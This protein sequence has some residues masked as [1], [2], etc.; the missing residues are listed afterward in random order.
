M[1]CNRAG[2]F[3]A[4][5]TQIGVN[6]TGN[7]PKCTVQI[8]YSLVQEEQG[9]EFVD[10]TDE[11]LT[12]TGYHYLEKNDKSLNL[13][14]VDALKAAL[15]WNPADGVAWLQDTDLSQHAVTVVVEMSEYNGTTRPKVQYLNPLGQAGG[16]SGVA[17][18]EPAALKQINNRLGSQLRALGG[19]TP[20]KAPAP[21]GKPTAPPP[22]KKLAGSAPAA[23]ITPC[24]REQAWEAVQDAEKWAALLAE[25]KIEDEEAATEADWGRVAVLAKSPF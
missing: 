3:N 8:S 5:P 17:K 12:I 10:I 14:T 22:A 4:Y 18:A 13:Y 24:T 9:G 1:L 20:A 2:V 7:P 19:G 23:G 15:G 25:C 11:G 21:K 6:D 16:A